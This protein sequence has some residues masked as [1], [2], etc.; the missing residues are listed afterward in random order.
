MLPTRWEKFTLRKHWYPPS[1]GACWMLE[2]DRKKEGSWNGWGDGNNEKGIPGV[3]HL[4][5]LQNV[6][7]CGSV[8]ISPMSSLF[9]N[10]RRSNSDIAMRGE[11][12]P[13]KKLLSKCSCRRLVIPMNILKGNG[14]VNRFS[15]RRQNN[16]SVEHDSRVDLKDCMATYLHRIRSDDSSNW[17]LLESSRSVHC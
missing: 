6:R 10:S 8:G 5:R 9:C 16:Q 4:H 11:I 1:P 2:G 15:P 7:V 3:W 12:V 17:S 13:V 14:P